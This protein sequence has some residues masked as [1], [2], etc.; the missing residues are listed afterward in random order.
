MKVVGR[1]MNDGDQE[2]DVDVVCVDGLL[3]CLLIGRALDLVDAWHRL[4]CVFE[5]MYVVYRVRVRVVVVYSC[6]V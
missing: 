1:Y 2:D 3:D 6:P 5:Y 4:E